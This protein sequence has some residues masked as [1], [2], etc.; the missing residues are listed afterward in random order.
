MFCCVSQSDASFSCSVN[1]VLYVYPILPFTEGLS[2]VK[3][4]C[5]LQDP[6]DEPQRLKTGFP[7]IRSSSLLIFI[8]GKAAIIVLYEGVFC[9]AI[10][11]FSSY[12]CPFLLLVWTHIAQLNVAVTYGTLN[13][14]T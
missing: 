12:C 8:S 11:F 7:V 9:L 5:P 10:I 13:T 2:I 6:H 3:R 1:S 4:A 14:V